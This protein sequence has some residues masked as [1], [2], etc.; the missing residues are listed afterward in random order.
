MPLDEAARRVPTSP[1]QLAEAIERYRAAGCAALASPLTDWYQV[2]LT[3][4]DYPSA[5]R[6]F[7]AYLLPVLQDAAFGAWWFVRPSPYPL[8]ALPDPL[9]DVAHREAGGRR[10]G[11]P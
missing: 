11:A 7:R 10:V 2:H 3:F 9:R 4:A 6:T 5:A 1:L 8:V